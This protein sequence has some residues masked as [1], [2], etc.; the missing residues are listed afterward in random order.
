MT[1]DLVVLLADAGIAK[2]ALYLVVMLADAPQGS[3]VR[4]GAYSEACTHST[5][6]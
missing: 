6:L 5:H 3:A 2:L 4:V 1:V